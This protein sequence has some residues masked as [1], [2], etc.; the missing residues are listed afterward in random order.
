[1]LLMRGSEL[2]KTVKDRTTVRNIFDKMTFISDFALRFFRN[3][4]LLNKIAKNV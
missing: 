3:P 4:Q 2:A 1:M